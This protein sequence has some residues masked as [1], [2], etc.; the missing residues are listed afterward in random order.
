MDYVQ[1]ELNCPGINK[2][3]C[4]LGLNDYKVN[5]DDINKETPDTSV[6]W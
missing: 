4:H 6:L 2:M 3:L 1:L 5:D